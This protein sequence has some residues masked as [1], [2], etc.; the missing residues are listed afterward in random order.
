LPGLAQAAVR[1]NDRALECWSAGCASGEEPYGLAILWRLRLAARF[2]G[3]DL[4]ILAT[5]LDATLLERAARG[6]YRPSSLKEVPADL[7]AAAFE[8]S[9]GE[10]CLRSD[11][12]QSVRLACQDIRA[13]MPEGVFDLIFCR[14]LVLTYFEPALRREVF[15]RILERLRAGGAVVIGIHERLPA[16][17]SQLAPWPGIRAIYRKAQ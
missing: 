2:P 15:G 5:D 3:V 16:P 11:F 8:A 9:G 17:M 10:L 14:N 6:C 4:R 13:P 1:R 12:R 7:R